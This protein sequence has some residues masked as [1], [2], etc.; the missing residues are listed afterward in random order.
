[1][2][3]ATGSGNGA[4]RHMQYESPRVTDFGSIASHTFLAGGSDNIKGGGDPQHLDMHCEWS[5][6]SDVNWEAC[7]DTPVAER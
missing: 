7:N 1:M 5:G 6:G 2:I 3:E 4:G